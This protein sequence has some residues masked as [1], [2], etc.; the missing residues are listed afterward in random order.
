MFKALFRHIV[1]ASTAS[2]SGILQA[3]NS[4]EWDA[5]GTAQEDLPQIRLR[6]EVTLQ[7]ETGRISL[8]SELQETLNIKKMEKQQWSVMKVLKPKMVVMHR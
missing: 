7:P 2:C 1:C 6:C 8:S 5:G 3:K 4:L